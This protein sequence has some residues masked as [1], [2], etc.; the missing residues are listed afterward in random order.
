MKYLWVSI[1]C[2]IWLFAAHAAKP[3]VADR[4][5]VTQGMDYDSAVHYCDSVPLRGPEGIYV[6]PDRGAIV[7]VRANSSN[8]DMAL[9]PGSYEIIALQCT[10]ILIAPGQTL[11]YLFPSADAEEYTLHLYSHISES[12]L[13]VPKR[14]AAKYDPM[15]SSFRIKGRRMQLTVN[16]LA[17][18]PKLRSLLRLKID[19]PL[20][21]IPDGLR[22]LYPPPAPTPNN[23]SLPFPRYF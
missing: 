14:Y 21:D 19:N 11:G 1:I 3:I 13:T 12:G 16:P 17:L 20:S 22:R 5:G 9:T 2:T 6:W 7:L 4:G 23:P 10:D 18:V 15:Q 8:A